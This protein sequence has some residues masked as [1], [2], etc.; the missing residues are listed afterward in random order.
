MEWESEWL[1]EYMSEGVRKYIQWAN[2]SE[3]LT[4]KVSQR[5]VMSELLKDWVNG[6]VSEGGW[7]KLRYECM[8]EWVRDWKNKSRMRDWMNERANEW[9]DQQ[10]KSEWMKGWMSEW[11]GT[12]SKSSLLTFFYK[13]VEAG[14]Y[15]PLPYLAP[16]VP[17]L[18]WAFPLTLL[19][20]GLVSGLRR[21]WREGQ[22]R[23]RGG[24]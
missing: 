4:E 22:G 21:K 23:G 5:C 20:H 3:W 16:A 7:E 13:F 8:S 17:Y 19:R 24:T 1:I 15:E 14:H 12:R 9:V 10:T 11:I 6:W 2:E 18:I